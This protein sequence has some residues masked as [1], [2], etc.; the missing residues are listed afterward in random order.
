VTSQEHETEQFSREAN[1][2]AF[3]VAKARGRAILSP[4]SV[5][6]PFRRVVTIS[7]FQLK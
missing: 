3:A 6:I 5:V 4:S 7:F 2:A 1:Q